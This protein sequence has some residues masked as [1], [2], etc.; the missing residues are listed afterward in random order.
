MLRNMAHIYRERRGAL[1]RVRPL[2]FPSFAFYSA[3]LPSSLPGFH[4]DNNKDTSA[5]RIAIITPGIDK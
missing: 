5:L 1:L 2:S 3:L 4:A